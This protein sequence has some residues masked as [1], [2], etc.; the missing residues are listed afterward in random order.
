MHTILAHWVGEVGVMGEPNIPEAL[1]SIISLVSVLPQMCQGGVLEGWV[2]VV[3]CL[4]MRCAGWRVEARLGRGWAGAG[5]RRT[6][7]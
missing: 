2:S 4:G 1:G 3:E 5:T 7:S 6:A